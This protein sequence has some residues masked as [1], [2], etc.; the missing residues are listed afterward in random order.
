LQRAGFHWRCIGIPFQPSKEGQGKRQYSGFEIAYVIRFRGWG[1]GKFAAGRPRSSTFADV[2]F[3]TFS[4]R[5]K[6]SA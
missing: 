5:S 2:F 4:V 3:R 6:D 1:Y